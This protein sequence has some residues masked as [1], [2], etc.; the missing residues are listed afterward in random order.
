MSKS[1]SV[2]IFYDEKVLSIALAAGAMLSLFAMGGANVCAAQGRD[3]MLPVARYLID[4]GAKQYNDGRYAD[5]EKTLLLAQGYVQY[6]PD[7]DRKKLDNLLEDAHNAAI[8]RKKALQELQVAQDLAAQNKPREA[9]EYLVKIKDNT[10]LTERERQQVATLMNSKESAKPERPGSL[11]DRF[12]NRL[13]LKPRSAAAE[14]VVEKDSSGS[15]ADSIPDHSEQTASNGPPRT[16]DL[17]SGISMEFVHIPAGS[18]DMGSP[19]NEQYRN[20]DEGPVRRVE[21]TEAF[22]LGKYEVTQG[23]Y[24][25][26]MGN[27]P[28]YLKSADLPVERVSWEDAVTFCRQL[29]AE[30]GQSC[31]LPTEAEWE[32]A[33]RAGST[34]A[35]CYSGSLDAST[36][37]FNGNSPY[38]DGP[39][40][41]FRM[42]TVTPGSFRANAW[43][44]HDMHG[45]VWEWCA[46][47]YADSYSDMQMTAPQGPSSGTSR[48]LRGGGW[49]STARRSRS[50]FRFSNRQAAR[51]STF[52]FRVVIADPDSGSIAPSPS[53]RPA[54]L[55]LG[56][57]ITM[58]LVHVPAGSFDMGSEANERGRENDEGPVR[59][60]EITKAFYLGKYE[61]TQDQYAAI[62][63]NDPSHF[64][65]KKLPVEM[66][67]WQDAQEFCRRLSAKTDRNCRLPTEAEWEYACRA[68]TNTAFCYGDSLDARTATFNGSYTYSGGATGENRRTTTSV[69][70]FKPNAWGLYDMHGNV[71]EW[72]RDW[73]D[74]YTAISTEDPRGP[75]SGTY[76]VLR[77]GSWGSNPVNC[78]AANRDRSS[79]NFTNHYYGFRVVLSVSED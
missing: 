34:T 79:P 69:G 22:Y 32:Y 7:K 19:P 61:V 10:Y 70:S 42:T 4:V 52:G 58:E 71:W 62:M 23:Q 67:S 76:R 25:A 26:V 78:R 16:F 3:T 51:H 72:C 20:V 36:A 33:C 50:A 28:S 45:N 15:P 6:L 39:E 46:D 21:I 47:W 65:G 44:L 54:A 38:G 66:V 63:G 1:R 35:F 64:P 9:R 75:P 60:V 56:N 29:A 18:F 24:M 49:T 8:G 48:V 74:S 41:K 17:G 13:G 40:G 5:A 73:Y 43:G 31:R 59:R 68:G 53:S 55:D 11:L 37:N 30:T 14:A 27:N 57:G 12:R 77:G 2:Q